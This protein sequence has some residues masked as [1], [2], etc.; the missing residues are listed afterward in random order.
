MTIWKTIPGFS[1][2]EVSDRGDIRCV[3]GGNSN[4]KIGPRASHPTRLG[5]L[6]IRLPDGRGNRPG[7]RIHRLVALAFLGEPPT[8]HHTDV[9]HNNGI[10]DDNRV[11]NLRWATRVENMAD[12]VEHGTTNR[13]ERAGRAKLTEVQVL[14]ILSSG[15]RNMDIAQRMGVARNTISQIR[16]GILWKHLQISLGK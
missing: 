1:R 5:Y 2:F 7:L 14:E 9:A 12:R 13:G 4:S 8:P 3:V 10:R 15:E 16:S 6:Q 11:E